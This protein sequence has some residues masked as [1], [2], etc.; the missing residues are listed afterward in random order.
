MLGATYMKDI[1]DSEFGGISVYSLDELT[2]II[3]ISSNGTCVL[4]STNIFT[5][6]GLSPLF[7]Y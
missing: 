4:I 5:L 2:E 6:A 7:E 3:S 1:F